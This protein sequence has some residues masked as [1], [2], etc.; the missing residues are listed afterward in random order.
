NY[1]F[2]LQFSGN[3][4]KFLLG[5]SLVTL[6]M[7][8]QSCISERKL[9]YFHDQQVTKQSLDSATQDALIRIKKGDR[10]QITV[11]SS[12]PAITAYLNPFGVAAS[13]SFEQQSNNGYLVN[14]EGFI[15]FP[16]VGMIKVDSL[17]TK[18]AGK[19]LAEKLAYWYR[20]LFV[21][22][23]LAGRVYFMNGRNGTT[24]PL[25]NERLTI[26]EAVSQSGMQDPY[27]VKNKVWLVREDDGERT[28]AQLDLNSKEI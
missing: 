11:S 24:I 7:A 12:D 4:N 9:Y 16:Q 3:M 28:F 1:S 27:D 17:T 19:L 20:D 23:N 2:S 25:R 13:V 21:D 8:L 26:F 6:L 18:E 14:E 10:L 15:D 22:V 5:L